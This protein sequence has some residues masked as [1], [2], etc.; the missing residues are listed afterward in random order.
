M[1]SLIQLIIPAL[2]FVGVVY[3]LTRRS[4]GGRE[5]DADTSDGAMFLMILTLGAIVAVAMAFV[6]QSLWE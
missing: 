4:D 2:I 3:L 1:R 6:L 5:R